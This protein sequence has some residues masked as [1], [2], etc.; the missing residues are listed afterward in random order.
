MRMRLPE[1]RSVADRLPAMVVFADFNL[2]EENPCTAMNDAG[3]LQ[4]DQC[5]HGRAG[6]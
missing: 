5:A 2:S 3:E 4:R 6:H 1:V